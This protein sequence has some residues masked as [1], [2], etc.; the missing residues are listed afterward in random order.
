MKELKLL[1][2]VCDFDFLI[3]LTHYVVIFVAPY[4]NRSIL[5]NMLNVKEQYNSRKTLRRFSAHE[6]VFA[7]AIIYYHFA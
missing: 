4:Y 3:I 7:Y 5:L 6:I 1:N 2:S